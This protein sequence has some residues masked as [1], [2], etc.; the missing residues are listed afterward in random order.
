[1]SVGV[2]HIGLTVPDIG[3]A[4]RFLTEA[5]GCVELFTTPPA[6]SPAPLAD[7]A[8]RALNVAPGVTLRGIAMLRSGLV[9][10]EL[11]EYADAALGA[12]PQNHAAG[13]AHIAFDV[14]DI[15][16]TAAAV[17]AAGGT[18]CG[19]VNLARSPGFE[20]LRWV[21]FIAPWGQTFE[22]V[23]TTAAPALRLGADGSA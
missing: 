19:P 23:D 22:L 10:I 15:E 5:L 16:A 6:A 17:V 7:A 8:A 3:E 11:F 9:L 4:R 20:G 14:Q 21:Y 1:M 2:H 13:A 12:P 18:L